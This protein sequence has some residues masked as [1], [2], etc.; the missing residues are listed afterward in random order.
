MSVAKP[1]A[2]KKR[3]IAEQFIAKAGPPVAVSA[4]V[5][6]FIATALPVV[7]FIAACVGLLVGLATLIYYVKQIRKK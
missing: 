3:M 1:S 4:T 6:S 5:T 2:W 7:Q